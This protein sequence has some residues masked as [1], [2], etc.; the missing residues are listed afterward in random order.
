MR[1]VRGWKIERRPAT[2]VTAKHRTAAVAFGVIAS[3][4]FGLLVSGAD[5]YVVFED[6]WT[7]SFG[8]PRG[9]E[10]VATL[11]LPLILTGLAAAIPLR[12]GLWNIGAEGQ[13]FMGAWAAAG[14]AFLFPDLAAPLLIPLMILG[15][16]VGGAL[17]IL[18]P[19]IARVRFHVNEIITTLLLNFV[20]IYWVLYWAGKP[21]RD[22][23]SVGGVKSES[24]PEQAEIPLLAFGDTE[25]PAAF[26]GAVAI[27]VLVWLVMRHTTL[28]YELT[29]LGAS[30]NSARFAGIPTKRLLIYALLAGGA[31]AGLAGALEMMGNAHRFGSAISNNTGYTGIV[32]AVLAAGSALGVVAMSIVFA[33]I[34]IIGGIFRAEGTSS[35]IIFAMYGLTLILAA[36]GQGL[37]HFK[38]RRDPDV[39][40]VDGGG[41]RGPAPYG[42]GET[43]MEESRVG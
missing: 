43:P 17:W 5:P 30:P 40:R 32:I 35:D 29:M 6:L 21:W 26:L 3:V 9:A 24:I 20:A 2:E 38:L 11:A 25:I 7:S 34:A 13:L 22:P 41:T 39:A 33:L 1:T 36:L 15:S 42:P 14:F 18:L 28:G 27:A 16:L 8:S 10:D 19:A 12:L 23:T 4:V 31:M 37:A